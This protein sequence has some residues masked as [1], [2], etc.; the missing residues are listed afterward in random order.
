MRKKI[1]IAVSAL[2]LILIFLFIPFYFFYLNKINICEP[3]NIS[4]PNLS[5]SETKSIEVFSITPLNNKKSIQ[6]SEADNCWW[7]NNGYHKAIDII[8]P[9]SIVRSVDSIIVSLS[10]KKYFI[11][12][13]DLKIVS[14]KDNKHEYLFP[15]YLQS[16][17]SI[18]K[19]IKALFRLSFGGT[20]LKLLQLLL[21]LLLIVFVLLKR[22]KIKSLFQ[23]LLLRFEHKL[24]KRNI[25]LR[26][27]I[28]WLK[29]SGISIFIACILFFSFLLFKFC[30]A[31]YIS[32]ILFIL[33]SGIL[34]WFMIKA[35]VR[36]LKISTAVAVFIKRFL[37]VFLLLWFCTETYLRI[38]KINISFNEKDGF[39]YSS[40]YRE[41]PQNDDKYPHLLV[42][43]KYYSNTNHLTE[44]VYKIKCNADG[45]RDIDHP[46][47]KAPDEF[48]IMCVGNSFTEGVGAPQDSTWTRLLENRLK[49]LVKRKITVFNAGKSGADPFFEYML[50]KEKMINY[51]PDLVLLTL[52]STDF[53]FYT[54]RGGFERFTPQG[55]KYRKGPDWEPLYAVSYIFRYLVRNQLHDKYLMSPADYTI[56]SIK[57]LHDIGQCILRFYQLSL[58]KKFKLAVV[59]YD[60]RNNSYAS[61]ISQLKK[62]N[63]VPVIDLFDYNKNV[64]KLSNMNKRQYYWAIDGHY[65]PKGYDLLARGVVWNLKQLG[66]T[67]S[68]FVK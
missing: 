5:A 30:V 65:N 22:E 17:H 15:A 2:F 53:S 31:N 34:L 45:L 23:S 63:I 38:E 44:F 26:K 58:D 57:A 16:E 42:Y 67:D 27:I 50:L 64:E 29:I 55:Y 51:N 8:I 6:Y 52:G 33:I 37:I 46:K 9:D 21:V 1:L 49:P 36:M 60:D 39:L 40:G 47:E 20:I 18:I 68:L 35:V 4:I 3:V 10:E 32:A 13:R 24:Q 66:I 54:F 43:P 56:D 59:F 14:L 62:E 12:A 28:L 7:E 19:K 61:I 25:S 48:R 41:T 11:P